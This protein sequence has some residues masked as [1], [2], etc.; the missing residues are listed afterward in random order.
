MGDAP[1]ELDRLKDKIRQLEVRLA[2]AFFPSLLSFL[3]R[4]NA[5]RLQHEA[6][7]SPTLSAEL[8]NP[9]KLS[10]LVI[11]AKNLRNWAISARRPSTTTA[12]RWSLLRCVFSPVL[13]QKEDIYETLED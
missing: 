3:L 1:N 5:N 9:N 8:L 11:L 7:A 10:A 12:T 2:V 4:R 6:K 13:R